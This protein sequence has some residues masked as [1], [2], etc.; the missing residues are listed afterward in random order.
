VELADLSGTDSMF[1]FSWP[2]DNGL[3]QKLT[4]LVDRNKH[5]ENS[6]QVS[7]EHHDRL[8]RQVNVLQDHGFVH[9]RHLLALCC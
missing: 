5:L 1:L 4:D 8:A 7:K 9:R 3:V 6:A 2:K